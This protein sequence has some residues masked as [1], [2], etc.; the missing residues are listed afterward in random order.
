MKRILA[1]TFAAAAPL[2]ALLWLSGAVPPHLAIAGVALLVFFVTLAGFLAL[3][4]LR[5]ADMPA[6]AAW[7]AG[8]FTSA[9]AV[10]A[11]VAWGGLLAQTAF[12]FSRRSTAAPVSLRL[13]HASR[14]ARPSARPARVRARHV[15]LAAD[16]RIHDVRGRARARHRARRQ[17]RGPC[18]RRSADAAPG[19]LDLRIAQRLS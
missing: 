6:S 19:C 1:T 18:I 4:A 2:S 15:F 12:A 10:Y 3:R 13:V 8:V 9:L 7:V 14:G 17:D 16:G 11:L 5:L